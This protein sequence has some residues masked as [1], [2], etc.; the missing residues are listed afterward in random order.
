MISL[1]PKLVA[2]KVQLYLRKLAKKCV[3]CKFEPSNRDCRYGGKC[4]ND[5]NTTLPFEQHKPVDPRGNLKAL[6]YEQVTVRDPT[7]VVLIKV[8]G[9]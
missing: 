3:L 9:T 2:W 7:F 5:S 8:G 4:G 6:Q 1:H